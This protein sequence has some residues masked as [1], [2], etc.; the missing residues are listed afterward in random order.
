MINEAKNLDK[1]L[2]L[3]PGSR[4]IVLRV[5]IFFSYSLANCELSDKIK[6]SRH[7]GFDIRQRTKKVSKTLLFGEFAS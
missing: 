2:I 7:T 3:I 5:L 1:Q 6:N 4:V